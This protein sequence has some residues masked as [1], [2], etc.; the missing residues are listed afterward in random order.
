MDQLNSWGL[1]VEMLVFVLAGGDV[2]GLR[3]MFC[4]ESY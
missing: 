2:P 1:P 3:E 4:N